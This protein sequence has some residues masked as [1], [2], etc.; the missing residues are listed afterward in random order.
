MSLWGITA[1]P[2]NAW[3]KPLIVFNTDFLD[4]DVTLVH[5]TGRNNI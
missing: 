4:D 3:N 5:S 2:K 1:R